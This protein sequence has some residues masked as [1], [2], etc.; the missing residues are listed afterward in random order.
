MPT[1]F[2]Q[3]YHDLSEK[4]NNMK[5]LSLTTADGFCL[6]CESEERFDLEEDKL[7]A[8]SSSLTALSNAAAKQLMSADFKSTFIETNKGLMYMVKAEYQGKSCILCLI[9]GKEPNLG[10][11]RYYVNALAKDLKNASLST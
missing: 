10:Q 8:V 11:I 6:F 5:A 2:K 3:I 1:T 7:S 9:S 4:V